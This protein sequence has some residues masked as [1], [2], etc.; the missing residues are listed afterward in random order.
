MGH[1]GITVEHCLASSSTMQHACGTS[2]F[3]GGTRL[4]EHLLLEGPILVE[5]LLLEGPMLVEHVLLEGPM[6]VESTPLS[7]A[8]T[9]Y[10]P[11]AFREYRV[12]LKTCLGNPPNLLATQSFD[13]A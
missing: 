6:L 11:L 12:D 8:Y 2:T 9:C 13:S 4:V 7:A 3:G 5:H 10:I 1:N